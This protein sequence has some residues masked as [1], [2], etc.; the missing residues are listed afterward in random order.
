VNDELDRFPALSGVRHIV[1]AEPEGFLLREDFARGIRALTARDL[2]YDILIYRG[3]LPEAV[4][5]VDRHPTQRFVL[6]HLAKPAIASGEIEPWAKELRR[7]AERANVWLK[8]SGL[9]SEARW[10][11]WQPRD[12][13][14][15]LD[16]AFEA[17]GA[18]RILFGSDHPVCRVAASYERV[19][20][21]ATDFVATLSEHEQ[22]LVLADNAISFYEL[23][24]L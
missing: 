20:R 24:S 3:Q 10:D 16:L 2:P 4:S 6:D 12:L 21:V 8:V 11:G 14:P 17:F 15:Y 18:E 19:L 13:E 23:A 7:L 22:S 9:V 5:F 1:Q